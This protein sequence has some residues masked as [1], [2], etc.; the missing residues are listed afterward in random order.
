MSPTRR[1][2]INRVGIA[3]ASLVATRCAWLAGKNAPTPEITCYLPA[4]P[5]DTPQSTEQLDQQEVILT[6]IARG[7]DV[8]PKVARLALIAF[9]RERLRSCWLRFDWLAEQSQDWSDYEKGEQALEQLKTEHRAAL[10]GLVASDGLDRAIANEVQNAFDAAAYHIWRAN[11]GMTCYEPLMMPD[12]TQSGSSQLVVQAD[13]LADLAD[14]A[15]IDPETIAQVQAAVERDI[16]FLN[17]SPEE[18]QALYDAVIEAAGEDYDYPTF[19]EL[20]LEITPEAAEAARF[21]V[22]LLLEE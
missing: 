8:D 6:A 19:E 4:V 18:E 22:E 12:Y 16:A 5:T 9:H 13:L 20:E 21:L 10:D 11:C 3:L 2:F 7:D 14:D 1:E 17:L 15:T